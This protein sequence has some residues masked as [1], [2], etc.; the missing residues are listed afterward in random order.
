MGRSVAWCK[1]D[2]SPKLLLSFSRLTSNPV[3]MS[4]QTRDAISCKYIDCDCFF[5]SL[6]LTLLHSPSLFPSQKKTFIIN[7]YPHISKSAFQS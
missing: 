5:F 2:T 3:E 7:F 4:E 1:L 6:Q